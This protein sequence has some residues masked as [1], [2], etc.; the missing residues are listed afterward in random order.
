MNNIHAGMQSLLNGQPIQPPL[1]QCDFGDPDCNP[2]LPENLHAYMIEMFQRQY[3][4]HINLSPGSLQR[5]D[6]LGRGFE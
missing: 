2:R 5:F 4:A 6:V 1:E 3:Q